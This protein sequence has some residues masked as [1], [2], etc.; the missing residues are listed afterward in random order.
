MTEEETEEEEEET[1]EEEEVAQDW[2]NLSI[3]PVSRGLGW[4]GRRKG[5]GS[6]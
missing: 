2:N 5:G 1:G 6:S 4:W 3:M